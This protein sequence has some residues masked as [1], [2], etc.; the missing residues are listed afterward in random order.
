MEL[1]KHSKT[2]IG[3][4]KTKLILLVPYTINIR[5]FS[6]KN[7]IAKI[8]GD[9]DSQQTK[10]IM[11]THNIVVCVYE[12]LPKVINSLAPN[13]LKNWIVVIDEV[14]NFVCQAD[15]RKDSLRIIKNYLCLFRKYI[16]ITGTP[17]GIVSELMRYDE[18]L[19]NIKFT[20]RNVKLVSEQLKIIRYVGNG[21]ATL[22]H[23]VIT[24]PVNGKT[25]IFIESK[26]DL[27]AIF[28]FLID[29]NIKPEDILFLNADEKHTDKFELLVKEEKIEENIKYILTTSVIADGGNIQN[30]DIDAF[31]S[32]NCIDLIKLRQFHSRIR[33]SCKNI[34]DFI[35]GEKE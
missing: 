18:N 4:M 9:V 32:L 7:K 8:D 2:S 21:L 33:E 10:S 5:Q 15:F 20:P 14:H 30:K 31:Y 34:Y 12:S 11:E 16:L 17:E 23:H 3:I 13:E 27:L 28:Y 19:I 6:F 29:C 22:M 25:I 26:H 1:L 24:N 35:P